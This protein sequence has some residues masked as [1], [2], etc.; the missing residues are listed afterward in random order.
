MKP[1]KTRQILTALAVAVAASL[2]ICAYA[3]QALPVPPLTVNGRFLQ[4][5]SGK[6]VLLHG[7]MQPGASWFNG[8]GANFSD[9]TD[10]TSTSN[11]AGMLNYYNAVADVFSKT[12]AQYGY[13]HGWYCSYVRLLGN[14]TSSGF[15]P[16]WDTNR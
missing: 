13:S 1:V 5:P 7:Y 4:D 11:V 10:Y 14:G 12:N 9:P 6:D 15:A 8:E 2:S 16:G 3:Y